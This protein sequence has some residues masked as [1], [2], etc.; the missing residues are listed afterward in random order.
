MPD[1]VTPGEPAA[2]LAG[3]D[4]TDRAHLDRSLARGVAWTATARWSAQLLT[5]AST[6]IV[7]RILSLSDYGIVGLATAYLGLVTM[8]S[9][10]GIGSAVVALR[11]LSREQLS[12]M[13]TVAVLFGVA[14]FVVSCA[15]A[16]VLS[17]FFDEPSL[18]VVVVALATIFLITGFRITPQAILQRELRF[19]DLAINDIVQAVL[20]SGA[21]VLFATLGFRYWTL[22]ISAVLGAAL[23]TLGILRLV[24]LPLRRPDW[25]ALAP[26]VRFSRETIIGRVG[27]YVYQNA[28]FF[29]VGKILGREAVG[30][31]R[32]AWDLAS[33][34]VE[35]ITSMVSRVT[36]SILS[37]AQHDLASLR[38]Y[39]L[40]ITEALALLVLPAAIGLAIVAED[41]VLIALGPQWEP[42]IVPLMF[43][44]ASIGFR[45]VASILP[46]FLA[47]TGETATTMRIN[48]AGAILLPV[49][50][51]IG[52]RWGVGGVAAV[53]ILIQPFTQEL[54]MARA[55]F[56]RLELPARD[57]L[58]SLAA[59]VT[60]TVI[61]T[62]AVFG[63]R[64]LTPDAVARPVHLTIDVAAGTA[65]YAASLMLFHRERALGV[66]RALRAARGQA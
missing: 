8:L 2:S 58:A 60:A 46:Q 17:W 48:L 14:G 32:F 36:P 59:P 45:S 47:V 16:P 37:A 66:V 15:L 7:A 62:A 10:F 42:A 21:A 61:M 65:A 38:R 51:V 44:A 63:A 56:R 22:V 20:V 35:K 25:T 40:R 34:P 49:A 12:Q 5:W 57:Y 4:A 18:T 1:D 23:S 30:A 31:Y 11:D 50:F 24:R 39:L 55:V 41:V 19:R 9:E 28:D 43:L 64:W 33:G 52:T 53:W 54:R 13:N 6:I 29:V 26:A 27:W 3:G